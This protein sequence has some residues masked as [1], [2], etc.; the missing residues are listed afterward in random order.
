MRSA[1]L[2]ACSRVAIPVHS[3]CAALDVTEATLAAAL[4]KRKTV[5]AFGLHPE[6]LQEAGAQPSRRRLQI[7]GAV[8]LTCPA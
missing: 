6:I 5:A 1:M 4:L 3:T 7:G 8:V 2:L